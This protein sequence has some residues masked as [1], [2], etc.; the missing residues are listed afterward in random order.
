MNHFLTVQLSSDVNELSSV[1]YQVWPNPTHDVIYVSGVNA[2]SKYKVFGVTG[3]IVMD[4]EMASSKID[5][6]DL[7]NGVYILVV[8][9]FKVKVI[10][11]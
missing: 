5:L 1:Q 6:S 10:K 3:N 2:G 4:G 8:D 9:Q 7:A 11:K